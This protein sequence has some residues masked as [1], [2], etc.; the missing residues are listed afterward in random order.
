MIFYDKVERRNWETMSST[1]FPG[2]TVDKAVMDIN[3]ES[4]ETAKKLAG[5]TISHHQAAFDL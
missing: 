3:L 4:L 5:V 2:W 1:M